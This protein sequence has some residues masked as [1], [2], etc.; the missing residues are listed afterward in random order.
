VVTPGSV[1]A[2]VERWVSNAGVA[3]S[4]CVKLRQGS[5]GAFRNE[6]SAQSGKKISEANAAILLRLV[7]LLG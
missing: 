6:L 2:L 4:M 3:N 5:Y 1:C 7:N